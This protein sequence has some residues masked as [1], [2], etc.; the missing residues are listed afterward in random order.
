[1]GRDGAG[2]SSSTSPLP[3]S[4][5]LL[6]IRQCPRPAIDMRPADANEVAEAWRVVMPLRHDPVAFLLSRQALPT[7]DRTKYASASGL[8]KGGYILADPPDGDPQVILIATG[9]EV[10][11]AVSAYEQLSADASPAS[12]TRTWHWRHGLDLARSSA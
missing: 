11:L 8:A 7:L 12:V 3:P 9:S 6:R 1:M 4:W 2:R 10:A 5:S